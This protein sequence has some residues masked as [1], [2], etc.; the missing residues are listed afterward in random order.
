[1]DGTFGTDILSFCMESP[2][3]SDRR[4]A[5]GDGITAA[6]SLLNSENMLGREVMV[7]SSRAQ[8]QPFSLRMRI[9]SASISA[10]AASFSPVDGSMPC[11]R[12]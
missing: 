11:E 3:P 5:T 8:T 2:A 4:A 6:A 10:E 9:A 7:G 1:M 12:R